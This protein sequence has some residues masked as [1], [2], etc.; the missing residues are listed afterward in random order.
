MKRVAQGGLDVRMM[1][2]QEVTFVGTYPYTMADFRDPVAAL[3][4]SVPGELS[5]IKKRPLAEG[6]A[7]FRDLLEGRAGAA[8]IVLIP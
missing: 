6:A 1:T 4:A 7:A 3:D 8:K 5:W 2:F